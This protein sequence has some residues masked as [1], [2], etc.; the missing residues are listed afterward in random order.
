ME[1]PILLKEIFVTLIVLLC[2]KYLIYIYIYI[3]IYNRRLSED[4]IA[5]NC[6]ILDLEMYL[7]ITGEQNV[8]TLILSYALRGDL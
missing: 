6:I 7:L 1:I 5:I 8:V 4:R 3:Y 2:R